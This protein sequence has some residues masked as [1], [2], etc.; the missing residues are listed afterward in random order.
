MLYL[1]IFILYVLSEQ[2]HLAACQKEVETLRI[3][4][5]ELLQDMASCREREADM[6]EFTQKVTA[7]NVRL[8]SEFSFIEAK[9]NLHINIM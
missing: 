1:V 5:A 3:S 2:E 9:V 6:L 8:Q 7:K 4:N